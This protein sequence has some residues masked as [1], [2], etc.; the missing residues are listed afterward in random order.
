MELEPEVRTEPGLVVRREPAVPMA[1]AEPP[2]FAVRAASEIE[3]QLA[4]AEP[5]ASELAGPSAS[6]LEVRMELEA[7]VRTD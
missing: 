7:A 2:A 5:M 4:F 6:E 1:S 3:E